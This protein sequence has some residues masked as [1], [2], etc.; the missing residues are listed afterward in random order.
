MMN[1][2]TMM[3]YVRFIEVSLAVT[4]CDCVVELP[5][6]TSKLD[7]N[8]LPENHMLPS[9]LMNT[10]KVTSDKQLCSGF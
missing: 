3:R 8:H 10:A 6:V 5:E 4:F 1:I 9:G 7:K 2:Y